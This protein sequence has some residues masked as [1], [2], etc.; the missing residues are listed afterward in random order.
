VLHITLPSKLTTCPTQAEDKPADI[1]EIS[2]SS[3]ADSSEDDSVIA[4]VKTKSLVEAR[5]AGA[6]T[7][8]AN[9]H[10]AYNAVDDEEEAPHALSRL[11]ATAVARFGPVLQVRLR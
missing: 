4:R 3:S 11:V 10:S 9:S 6:F 1:V 5:P 7:G 2:S 8:A